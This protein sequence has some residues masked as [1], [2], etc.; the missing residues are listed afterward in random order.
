MKLKI[1]NRLTM[2]RKL[3]YN[4][5]VAELT[6]RAFNGGGISPKGI[7]ILLGFYCKMLLAIPFAALQH[8][9]YGS[10]VR[11]EK[12]NEPPVFILGHYRSGT[13]LLH[14]LMAG[15]E[16]FGVLTNY[17]MVC[18]NTNL[19]FGKRLKQ[20]LQ[21]VINTFG[22]KTAFF[23]NAV[24]KLSEPSEEDRYLINKASAYCPYWGFVFPKSNWLSSYSC[25][26]DANM[27]NGWKEEYL[28]TL[29]FISYINHGKRLLLKNPPNTGR[30]RLLLEMFPDAKFIYIYRNPFHLFYSMKNMWKKAILKF[31]CVQKVSDDNLDAIIFNHYNDLIARYEKDKD[32]IPAGNLAVVSYEELRANPLQTIERI[33]SK[34][35]LPGFVTATVGIQKQLGVESDYKNFRYNYGFETFR[36]IEKQWGKTVRQGQYQNTK[37]GT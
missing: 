33:Y 7:L 24:A 30:I 21:L 23:N 37:T 8:M 13:T 36:M 29:K 12:I 5:P 18:P 2:R 9:F 20:L 22:I 28:H 34:L 4:I 27:V 10:S 31:Y 35:N 25:L 16:R 6:K 3:L 11:K 1:K 32:L 17:E 19:L 26:T 15:D 14:K